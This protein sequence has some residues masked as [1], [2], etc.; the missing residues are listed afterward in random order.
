MMKSQFLFILRAVIYYVLIYLSLTSK[1][2]LAD[3][4]YLN[5]GEEYIGKLV[6]I[7]KDSIYFE[8][9]GDKHARSLQKWS[10]DDVQRIEFE[11]LHHA[12][13]VKELKDPLL[14]SLFKFGVGA[15]DYPDA[16][17]VTLYEK[18][19]YHINPD[20][21]WTKTTRRIQKVLRPRG[22][23]IASQSFSYLSKSEKLGLKFARVIEPS[24]KLNWLREAAKKDESMWARFPEY[25]NEHRIRFALPDIPPGGISDVCV[26]QNFPKFST[27]HPLLIEEYFRTWEPIEYK[28]VEILVP[29]ETRYNVSLQIFKSP[30]IKIDSSVESGRKIY[31]FW[32]MKSKAI[33][34]E[35]YLPPL[36]DIAPRLVVGIQD[37]WESIGEKYYKLIESESVGVIYELS[38]QNKIKELKSAH[39][40]YNFVATEIKSVPITCLDQY[41]WIPTSPDVV[42]KNKSGSLPDRVFLL[43]AMLKEVGFD[44]YL[45]MTSPHNNGK[46]V[47]GIPTLAQFPCFIVEIKENGKS[48]W[49]CPT[50]DRTAY[51]ELSP[52][53]YG[54][55]GFR[56]GHKSKFVYIPVFE[57]E[58]ECESKKMHYKLSSDGTLEVRETTELS[59]NFAQ[60]FRQNKALKCEELKKYF[61]GFVSKIHPNAKLMG[62]EVSNL[63]DLSEPVKYGLNYKIPDYALKSGDKFLVFNLPGID[64]TAAEVGKKERENPLDFKQKVMH[65]SQIEIE[66]P[67]NY[68]VYYLPPE[69][70]HQS[71]LV[72]YEARFSK[73]IPN[74]F[75]KLFG[76]IPKLLFNDVYLRK[77]PKIECENYP[78]YK[79]C[80][81][82]R[83]KLAKELVV[84]KK[85]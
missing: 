36:K 81:E 8:M 67:E 20:S 59:G 74:F 55:L 7:K 63:A 37:S 52:E 28:S 66:I 15:S 19:I 41:S 14:D 21:S 49:L 53:Y 61:E 10:Q 43:Y 44:T 35:P 51:G 12:Q 82:T 33:K 25:E 39:K 31:H 64:Y 69:Y 78:D 42:F 80:I 9:E 50:D 47:Q 79:S 22:R 32:S 58:E 85:K 1:I 40:I 5:K 77:F 29:I 76:K 2:L 38:L 16:A 60:E 27:Q 75:Q 84:L 18:V 24:G 3:I 13:W 68:G 6:Q 65:T 54:R 70:K 30:E 73:E 56:L 4:I 83:A 45:I 46:R 11:E 48:R 23:W 26:E 62:F 34:E 72:S 71:E 57:P 17:W